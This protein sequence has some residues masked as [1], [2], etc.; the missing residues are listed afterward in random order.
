MA[1]NCVGGANNQA[2]IEAQRAAEE[3][4]RAEE[5]RKRE[6]ER[7][8]AEE[9]KRK[10]LEEQKKLQEKKIQEQQKK[11]QEQQKS[12]QESAK[13]F[14]PQKPD[15]AMSMLTANSVGIGSTSDFVK[16]QNGESQVGPTKKEATS[17]DKTTQA[18]KDPNA[19]KDPA[20]NEEESDLEKGVNVFLDAQTGQSKSFGVAEGALGTSSINKQVKDAKN[21][22]ATAD[23][24]SPEWRKAADFM[25]A[26]RS[27]IGNLDDLG[28]S[29]ALNVLNRWAQN[30]LDFTDRF[31]HSSALGRTIGEATDGL[32]MDGLRSNS[33]LQGHGATRAVSN[34]IT[35]DN[36]VGEAI[37]DTIT[38][39]NKVG[40]VLG[41]VGFAADGLALI[42][43][44][45]NH[46][47]TALSGANIAKDATEVLG[48]AAGLVGGI[49]GN[50]HAAGTAITTASDVVATAGT[51]ASGTEYGRFAANAL[52]KATAAG[53]A[54]SDANA[55]ATAAKATA[56]TAGKVAN[57]A[58]AAGKVLGVAGGALSI[59]IGVTELATAESNKDKF[60][61]V[62][63]IIS[64]VAGVAS[65]LPP[66]AGTV[67]LGI[68]AG[69]QLVKFVG[70]LFDWD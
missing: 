36:S 68:S 56:T 59:G 11:V 47:G 12:A 38:G 43:D 25:Y 60:D 49:A 52:S 34:T 37:R 28:D 69:A 20:S 57:V 46:D 58:S 51:V 21:V 62:C 50:V 1:V 13:T 19:P 29:K 27:A 24:S 64:G 66:P 45:K 40:K 53:V 15:A 48:D 2:A 17:A 9:A 32:N 10:K 23:P 22:L 31:N 4:R 6:E 70:G 65:V 67:A 55:V 26:N 14:G 5:A 44:I 33:F 16:V 7:K 8:R 61:G 41:G 18:P 54:A 35:G 42:S 39:D 30:G 3:K 63:D